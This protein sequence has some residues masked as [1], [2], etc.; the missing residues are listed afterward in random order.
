MTD[1]SPEQQLKPQPG[2]V[3]GPFIPNGL[4]RKD[5]TNDK[6]K[7]WPILPGSQAVNFV[8]AEPALI[9]FAPDPNAHGMV[10]LLPFRVW[11]EPAW[12]VGRYWSFGAPPSEADFYGKLAVVYDWNS[13][14]YLCQLN[15]PG[16]AVTIKGWTGVVARQPAMG[17]DDAGKP[18]CFLLDYHLPGGGKQIYVPD[19][20][21]PYL[22][23]Q[24]TRWNGPRTPVNP[25][26][27]FP[28]PEAFPK[29]VDPRDYEQLVLAAKA[30][31][32]LLTS[33]DTAATSYGANQAS[34]INSRINM[35]NLDLAEGVTKADSRARARLTLWSLVATGRQ[36]DLDLSRISEA[37][38]IDKAVNQIVE[39]SLKIADALG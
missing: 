17:L 38:A 12:D 19:G 31:S 25:G 26:K 6:D 18:V 21:L 27:P 13:A 35:L 32:Q 15:N 23:N 24:H 5:V 9:T 34:L 14:R 30:L 16:A 20:T 29:G 36:V 3:S 8:D 33:I 22:V 11:G 2:A 37:A 4:P 7:T 10:S 39:S 1:K 28:R